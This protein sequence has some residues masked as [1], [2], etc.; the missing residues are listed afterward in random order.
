M[1]DNK[2]RAP[3]T[4]GDSIIKKKALIGQKGKVILRY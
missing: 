2:I 4:A 3:Q 1:T